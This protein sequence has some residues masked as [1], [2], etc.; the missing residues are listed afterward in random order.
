MVLA[1]G[2][3]NFLSLEF[4]IGQLQPKDS[5]CLVDFNSGATVMFS[6]SAMDAD[7]KKK[8]LGAVD[9]LAA[10]GIPHS[11]ARP[12][13][14]PGTTNMYAGL[15]L[16]LQQLASTQERKGVCSALL[17]TDG[18][19]DSR[20]G[21]QGLITPSIKQITGGCM[22]QIPILLP[23]LTPKTHFVGTLHTFGYGSDHDGNF[24]KGLSDEG[25]GSYY[26]LGKPDDIP[27]SFGECLP[28]IPSSLF[29]QFPV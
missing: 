8:A 10:T 12:H 29:D 18:H 14:F 3:S 11:L 5:F 15:Q 22:D 2:P 27:N 13:F 21:I 4:V 1:T 19:P 24:L 16:G 25:K 28:S 17:F 23:F 7:Q 20:E 26:F 9:K 6:L